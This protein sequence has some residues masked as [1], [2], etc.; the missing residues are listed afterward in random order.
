MILLVVL[1]SFYRLQHLSHISTYFS[2]NLVVPEQCLLRYPI[3]L[4]GLHQS[5]KFLLIDFDD[6]LR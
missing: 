2:F 1:M 5:I 4:G 6:G 3:D